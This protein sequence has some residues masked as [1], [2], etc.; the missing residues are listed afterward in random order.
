[1]SPVTG[2]LLDGSGPRVSYLIGATLLALAMF[3]AG[4]AGSLWHLYLGPGVL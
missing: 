3:V 4:N 2:W 1:M